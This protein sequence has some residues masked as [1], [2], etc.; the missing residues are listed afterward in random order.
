MKT[1]LKIEEFNEK[2]RKML[3]RYYERLMKDMAEFTLLT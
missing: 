1:D 3:D 2:S